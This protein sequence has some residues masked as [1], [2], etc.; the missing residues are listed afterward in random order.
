MRFLINQWAESATPPIPPR[1]TARTPHAHAH[2]PRDSRP[3]ST[4]LCRWKYAKAA[5]N[6]SSHA[7]SCATQGTATDML[8]RAAAV[9]SV[10]RRAS[11]RAGT[12]QSTEN[13]ESRHGYRH[14]TDRSLIHQIARSRTHCK[15][16]F[17]R[18]V[19]A[20]AVRGLRGWRRV[21]CAYRVCVHAACV[22]AACVHATCA[23]AA[24]VH[25]ACCLWACR[26]CA[27]VPTGSRG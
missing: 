5:V 4:H 17:H 3:F 1:P 16:P 13:N 20:H 22:H 7:H 25:A 8:S 18:G 21:L 9:P 6:A 12:Y 24:R 14:N 10:R 27:G 2:T 19:V 23:H 26:M 11:S 15:L